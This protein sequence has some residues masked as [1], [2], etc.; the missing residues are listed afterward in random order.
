MLRR[1]ISTVGASGSGT[2]SVMAERVLVDEERGLKDSNLGQI[3][4][5]NTKAGPHGNQM[6][7]IPVKTKG[8]SKSPWPPALAS[9]SSLY[10]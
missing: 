5:L 7:D 8:V 9:A 10:K 3:H 4:C 1:S 6:I 2:E